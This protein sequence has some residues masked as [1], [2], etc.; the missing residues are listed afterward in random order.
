MQELLASTARTASPGAVDLD[1]KGKKGVV[2]V[3]DVTAIAATP[4]LTVTIR[5]KD[6]SGKTWTIL[7]SAAI[8]GTGTTTLKVYPGLTAAANAVAND[9]IPDNCEVDFSH[10]DA[11]SITYSASAHPIA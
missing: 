3:I 1:Q 5:G 10:G 8:T 7:A 9:V 11:D 2:V 6:T 4:S